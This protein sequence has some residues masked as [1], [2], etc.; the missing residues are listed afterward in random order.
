M[1]EFIDE[2]APDSL[3]DAIKRWMSYPTV[4]SGFLKIIKSRSVYICGGFVRD[5][6][7][8]REPS[9]MDVYFR[10]GEDFKYA[11]SNLSAC[12]FDRFS[13]SNRAVTYVFGN[14]VIQLIDPKYYV[15]TDVESIINHFDF[16]M[17]KAGIYYGIS[18][19]K[20]HMVC[21]KDFFKHLVSKELIYCGNQ[22]PVNSMIRAFKFTERGYH[23]PHI[24]FISI[25]RDITSYDMTDPGIWNTHVSFSDSGGRIKELEMD[26]C[27]APERYIHDKEVESMLILLL[28]NIMDRSGYRL[29][30]D[31]IKT[32]MDSLLPFI[33]SMAKPSLEE[34]ENRL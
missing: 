8:K 25:L 11:I 34:I 28:N 16:T 29:S 22:Y 24:Q 23:L 17:C 33:Q 2:P 18:N 14:R 27:M 6:L 7:S 19:R 13:K 26:K 12:K 4:L 10:E 5:V 31:M 20:L 9:D 1:S 32:V 21:H 3:R 15:G 30:Q